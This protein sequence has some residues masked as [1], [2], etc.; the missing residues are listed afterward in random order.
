M[1]VTL[2]QIVDAR[3]A[4]MTLSQQRLNIKTGYNISK[5]IRLANKELETLSKV[6]QEVIDRIAP[7]GTE[8]TP[9]IN[10]AIISELSEVLEETVDFP[11]NKIDLSSTPNLE[12][13]ARDII[14]LEPFCIFDA[15]ILE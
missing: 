14:L 3:E 9:E 2:K 6:R 15:I 11:V 8:M 1:Q 4:L 5:I 13:T 12:M 7:T 10:Q